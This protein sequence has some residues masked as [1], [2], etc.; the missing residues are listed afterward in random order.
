M[1][2]RQGRYGKFL[3]CSDYPNC[4]NTKP[5]LKKLGIKCPLCETGE[6]IERKSK[7]LKVF[8]GCSEFPKC[9]FVSWDQPV[10]RAC[11]ECGDM[12]VLKKTKKQE[13]IKCH[14]STCKYV[15]QN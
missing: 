5:I 14:S 1:L 7:K 6:I 11:P 12:L 4:D 15:E 3:A 10:G 13:L 9:N 8:Y 2:I